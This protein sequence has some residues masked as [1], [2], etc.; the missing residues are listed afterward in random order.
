VR[1]ALDLGALE[2]AEVEADG[3]QVFLT[4]TAPTEAKRFNALSTAWAVVDAARVIDQMEVAAS[5]VFAPL[6]FS[7]EILRNRSGISLI[8]L[9][10]V[11]TGREDFLAT[12]ED[13]SDGANISD[14]LE[15]A[16]YPTPEGWNEALLFAMSAL[17]ILPRSKISI[18]AEH[19]AITAISDSVEAKHRLEAEL[20]RAA[21][22]TVKL[23]LEISAP[24]P[25]IT[26]FALRFVID[27]N[28]AR[29]EGCAADTEIA[30]NRITRAATTAGL[31]GDPDCTLAL[32]SPSPN[33]ATAAEKSIT[34]LAT[35]SGPVRS[36]SPMPTSL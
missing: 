29:F 11:E 33:W 23:S 10:P 2:W 8:G 3:L 24:R 27:Q 28:G 26:P 16:D 19:V 13:I 7:I 18:A 30:K 31:L 5:A 36:R 15:T 25:V 12:L 4:G 35:I 1:R 32:G 9:I 6:R 20:A 21:P 17:E 14:F 34:A 22:T